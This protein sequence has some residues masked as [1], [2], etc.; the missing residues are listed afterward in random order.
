MSS[1]RILLVDDMELN[2]VILKELLREGDF[3]TETACNGEEA[4]QLS[5]RIKFD[6]ILM[7]IQMP[8]LN[9]LEA[10][11]QIRGDKANL[12][13]LTPIIAL[14]ANAYDSDRATY[15]E[16]GMNDVLLKPFDLADFFQLLAIYLDDQLPV[17]PAK[18]LTPQTQ[19][20]MHAVKIVIDNLLRIGKNNHGFV[21][22]MLHSFRDSSNEII[23]D[24]EHCLERKDWA[25]TAQLVHKLKFALNVM[26][27]GSLD[28]E[29]RWIETHTRNP[30]PENED[31]MQVRIR[32]FITVIR[33]LYQ[34]AGLLI[35]SGEWS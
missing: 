35:E 16:A 6:L 1:S 17:Q 33:E 29:V 24:M 26:G 23:G 28:E 11:S 21:G 10:T 8:L 20:G 5:R 25:K 19:L 13:N 27:A 3:K 14:S 7:D 2:L 30:Q 4:V 22:M 31:E 9:G 15:I 12:N 32:A 18:S 34:H